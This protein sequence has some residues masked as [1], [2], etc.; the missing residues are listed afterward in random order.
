M[1]ISESDRRTRI[2]P[3]PISAVS[4]LNGQRTGT[5]EPW[6]MRRERFSQRRN[7][8]AHPIN[9]YSSHFVVRSRGVTR[10]KAVIP[11]IVSVE[12]AQSPPID[13][14]KVP[15]RT[16]RAGWSCWRESIKIKR[17]KV[18]VRFTTVS[19]THL[20]A[21]ETPEHLVCRLLL[22]K[23]KNTNPRDL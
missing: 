3:P 4:S 17:Y 8:P 19:Y 10:G 7:E 21:H 14:I 15:E 18:V 5:I 16:H 20:R 12:A 11:I 9:D 23:K 22:E 6:I 1:K 13:P 2:F